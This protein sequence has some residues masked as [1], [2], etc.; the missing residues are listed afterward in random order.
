MPTF[1][2]KYHV[3]LVLPDDEKLVCDLSR[4][5]VADDFVTPYRNGADIVMGDRHLACGQVLGSC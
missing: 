1:P 2:F 5:R 3:L 4:R